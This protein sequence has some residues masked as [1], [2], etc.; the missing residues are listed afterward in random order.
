[1]ILALLEKWG[2]KEIQV[3]QALLED[4]ELLQILGLQAQQV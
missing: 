2:L 4:K 3:P 1:V